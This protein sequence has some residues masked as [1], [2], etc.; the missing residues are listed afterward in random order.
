MLPVHFLVF[1]LPNVYYKASQSI[2]TNGKSKIVNSA[3]SLRASQLQHA[4]AIHHLKRA[5]AMRQSFC[6]TN[7]Y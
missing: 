1:N 6:R 3:C 5:V 2:Q 7:Y 4:H